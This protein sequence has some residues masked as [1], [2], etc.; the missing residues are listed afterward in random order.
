MKFDVCE[1]CQ[2]L[3]FRHP[4]PANEEAFQAKLGELWVGLKLLEVKMLLF[5]EI[6]PEALLLFASADEE[7]FQAKMDEL[8]AELKF[9]ETYLSKTKYLA[10][11]SFTLADVFAGK[12]SCIRLCGPLSVFFAACM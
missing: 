12:D 10:G 4:L 9:W 1:R 7:A 5:W 6:K 11:P 3:T 2:R 8:R